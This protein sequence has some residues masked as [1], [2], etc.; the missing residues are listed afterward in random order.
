VAPHF[1]TSDDELE[2][3]VAAMRVILDN[4][5]WRDFT[6]KGVVT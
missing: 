5:V 2:M 3:A 4:G 6:V 1:Y